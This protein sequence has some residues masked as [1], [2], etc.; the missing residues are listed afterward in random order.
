[1][2]RIPIIIDCDPGHDDVGAIMMAIASE[3]FDIKGITC[4][5][6]NG[7]LEFLPDN[8]LKSLTASTCR[9][10]PWCAAWRSPS[11]ADAG[12]RAAST[13]IRASTARCSCPR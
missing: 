10:S 1:M 5:P 7:L 3:K 8:M 11:G 13:A 4:V 6:G 12:P 9:T 2:K